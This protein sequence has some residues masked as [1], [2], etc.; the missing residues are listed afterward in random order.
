MKKYTENMIFNEGEDMKNRDLAGV[1]FLLFI[2][3]SSLADSNNLIPCL[4]F[5]GAGLVTMAL[6]LLHK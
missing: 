6:T 1:G 3:G 4:V 2:V 5:A